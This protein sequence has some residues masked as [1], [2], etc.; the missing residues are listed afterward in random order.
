[1]S[2]I[3]LVLAAIIMPSCAAIV[4][5]SSVNLFSAR[6]SLNETKMTEAYSC[7]YLAG[8]YD[9]MNRMPTAFPGTREVPDYC[10]PFQEAAAKH[11]FTRK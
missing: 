4:I 9:I 11:G 7:A 3:P 8:Q 6:A 5:T 2:K 10:A 1:M